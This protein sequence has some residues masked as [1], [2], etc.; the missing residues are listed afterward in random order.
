MVKVQQQRLVFL[1]CQIGFRTTA[2]LGNI[3][4]GLRDVGM[5]EDEVAGIM[6]GNWY[7]FYDENFEP[8][9]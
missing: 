2:T 8:L 7:R 3:E 1:Q 9:T 6:G 5:R 4:Q